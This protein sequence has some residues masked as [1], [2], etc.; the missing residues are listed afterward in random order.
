[1][2]VTTNAKNLRQYKITFFVTVE[3]MPPFDSSP[4]IVRELKSLPPNFK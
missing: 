2:K 4:K 1:M 3:L